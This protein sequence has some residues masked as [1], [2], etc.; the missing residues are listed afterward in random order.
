MYVYNLHHNSYPFQIIIKWLERNAKERL[1][2]ETEGNWMYTDKKGAQKTDPDSIYKEKNTLDENDLRQERAIIKK[3]WSLVRSGQVKEAQMFCRKHDQFWRAATLAGSELYHNPRL[4]SKDSNFDEGLETVGNQNR[5]V[6]LNSVM[7]MIQS[8]D[9]DNNDIYNFEK[10]IYGTICGDLQSMLRCCFTWED[11]L[12]AYCKAAL[13]YK[14]NEKLSQY[15]PEDSEDKLYKQKVLDFQQKNN[16]SLVAII[17][18]LNSSSNEK[19]REE[20]VYY[21]HVVQSFIMCDKIP[22]LV[23][24][25]LS[26]ISN[27]PQSSMEFMSNLLRFSAHFVILWTIRALDHVDSC[28]E[29]GTRNAILVKFIHY[30]IKT[31]QYD[32]I[33]FYTRYIDPNIEDVVPGN[34]RSILYS[35]AVVAIER[36]EKEY[37]NAEK[38][39]TETKTDEKLE[40]KARKVLRNLL[41]TQAKENNLDVEEIAEL[42]AKKSLDESFPES[43]FSLNQMDAYFL[44]D[45]KNNALQKLKETET[46]EQDNNKINSIDWLCIDDVRPL[47]CLAYT[48]KLLREFVRLG[49]LSAFEKT[50]ENLVKK[51]DTRLANYDGQLSEKEEADLDEYLAWRLYSESISSYDAWSQHLQVKPEFKGIEA[52]TQSE[53]SKNEMDLLTFTNTTLRE[54]TKQN[55]ELF[56]KAKDTISRLVHNP[57]L[58]TKYGQ[59]SHQDDDLN[60]L[61]HLCL[62]DMVFCLYQLLSYEE[63]HELCLQ[64]ADVVAAEGLDLYKFFSKEQLV[65]LLKLMQV[66][67]LRAIQQK[68]EE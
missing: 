54:W 66:S 4:L 59:V 5:F 14:I 24:Y 32:V 40:E 33:A 15:V 12:W 67:E 39:L 57:W 46:T 22:D 3:T 28:I 49:K 6:Y 2:I 11:H 43:Q 55:G 8:D 26:T 29:F 63:E 53:K 25:L 37:R 7:S 35:E 58:T 48:N 16:L 1:D 50:M 64:L 44:L 13:E 61:K 18:A 21:H 10:S 31:R 42:V 30:L 56:T 51:I 36:A 23:E 34:Y 52:T 19:I 68:Q 62:P 9:I 47:I 60:K 45:P 17:S 41:L 38:L 65:E 27:P 20:A